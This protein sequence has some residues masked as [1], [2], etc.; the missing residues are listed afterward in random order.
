MFPCSQQKPSSDM[1]Y[2][3]HT[4]VDHNNVK[5]II[6]YIFLLYLIWWCGHFWVNICVPYVH[7]LVIILPKPTGPPHHNGE[8]L[9]N[10]GLNSEL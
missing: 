7:M 3:P 1:N 10:Y 4:K 5:Y 6:C 2:N 9:Q 8:F